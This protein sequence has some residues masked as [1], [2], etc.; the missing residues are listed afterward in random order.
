MSIKE[1]HNKL[2][3]KEISACQLA[4]NYLGTIEEKDK[5]LNAFL[6]LTKDLALSQASETD[7]KIARGENIGL[8][9]GIPCAI[10]DN[11]LVEKERCT[12]ASKILENYK[13]VYDA[14]AVKKLKEAGAVILGKTN[15]DEFAMGAS[16]E[17]S[18]FG[19]TKNP[20]DLE[21]V[22]GGT[23]GGSAAAVAAHEAPF[24]LGS[25]TNGSIRQPASFCGIVGLKP[26]YGSVSRYG[27]IAMASSFDVIG[28]MA[29]SVDEAKIIFEVIGGK[30][31]YDS[32]SDERE[33]EKDSFSRE[34]VI[35][36]GIPK[37][38]YREGLD[39]EIRDCLQNLQQKLEGEVI[40]QRKIE[41]KKIS[42]P[43]TEYAVACY[44]IITPSEV[45]ANLARYD[46]IRYGNNSKRGH[47]DPALIDFYSDLRGE[48][49]GEEVRR[50][51]ILGTFTLSA[52]YYEAYYQ[53]AQEVRSLIV[54]DFDEAFKEVDLL[55]TPTTPSV[56]F[57]IGAKTDPLDLYLCDI[58]TSA[59]SL[60]G[61]PAASLPVGNNY[62]GLPMGCQ[63]IAPWFREERIF[64]VGSLI[65]RVTS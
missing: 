57:K 26:T 1:L 54:K 36:I 16:T 6:S 27:L 37:E 51:I 39:E 31:I 20:H 19:V 21:R 7:K 15:L 60:S 38:Y 3:N 14:T 12:A 42:L 44:Y 28:P 34:D 13:A 47:R 29:L 35:V 59:A 40:G 2:Q 22:P 17:N 50:R 11:I 9:E 8:L 23:S 43:H 63:L 48:R 18:A 53:K 56:A 46:G 41:L 62:Q 55:L 52:G 58:Y 45:S 25:D 30:D 5:K 49:L 32:T 33:L 65:E 10:K 24:A 4:E 61:L 64:K